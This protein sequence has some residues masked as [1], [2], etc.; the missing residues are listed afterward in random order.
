MLRGNDACP[1]HAHRSCADH[2]LVHPPPFTRGAD[3]HAD[4]VNFAAANRNHDVFADPHQLDAARRARGASGHLAF[5]HGA[6]ECPDRYLARLEALIV[7]HTLLLRLADLHRIGPPE[8]LPQ[9][10]HLLPAGPNAW[11]WS[12]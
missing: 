2:H 1:H 4:R 9:V 6:R 10:P 11:T 8:P 7:I 3:G 12:T 5:G